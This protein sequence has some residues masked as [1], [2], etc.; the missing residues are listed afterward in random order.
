MRIVTYFRYRGIQFRL[1]SPGDE[2]RGAFASQAAGAGE[3]DH[4]AT[5]GHERHLSSMLVEWMLS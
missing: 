5:T 4:G 1:A 2:H 3:A